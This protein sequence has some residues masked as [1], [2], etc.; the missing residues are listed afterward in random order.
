[1]DKFEFGPFTVEV[2]MSNLVVRRGESRL[3]FLPGEAGTAA[4]ILSMARQMQSMKA[5]PDK[6]ANKPWEVRFGSDGVLEWCRQGSK[7]GLKFGFDEADE[8][9]KAVN[10]ALDKY[11]DAI[12]IRGGPAAGVAAFQTPDPPI[13]GRG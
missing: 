10:T 5:L 13:D 3:Q 2:E 4:N 11:V 8:L 6:I 12:R 7:S 9:V 1:M